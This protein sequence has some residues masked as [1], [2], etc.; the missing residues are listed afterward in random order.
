[1]VSFF[2]RKEGAGT[3]KKVK[4]FY[5]VWARVLLIGQWTRRGTIHVNFYEKMTK[6]RRFGIAFQRKMWYK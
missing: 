5:N 6:F 4:N 1:M 2:V 3:A